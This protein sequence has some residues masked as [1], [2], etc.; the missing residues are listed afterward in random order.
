MCGL[1]DHRVYDGDQV[2]GRELAQLE[3]IETT[4]TEAE[5]WLGRMINRETGLIH[6]QKAK[7]TAAEELD[8][9]T[10]SRLPSLAA[11]F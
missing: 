4:S 3:S 6:D 9:R 10:L 7:H 5:V 1:G 2:P 8:L 11:A